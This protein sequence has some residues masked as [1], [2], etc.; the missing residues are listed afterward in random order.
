MLNVLVWLAAIEIVGIAAFPVAY[1]LFPKLH[2]RGYSLAKPL[3]VL[4]VAYVSWILSTLHI[5]PSTLL[6]ILILL[7][8]LGA[9]STWY[10]IRISHDLISLWRRERNSIIASEIIFL[11]AFFCWIA[12]RAYDPAINHTEQPM[13]FAFLNATIRS[14]VGQPADPWLSG[15]YIS[16]YYFGYWMMSIIAKLTN[17]SASVSYNLGLA[18]IPAMA[19]MGLFGLVYSM[20]RAEVMQFPYRL[21]T[22]FLIEPAGMLFLIYNKLIEKTR[23]LRAAFIGGIAAAILV[24]ATANLEGTLEFA[25]ANGMGS[26]EFWKHVSIQGMEYSPDSLSTSW[27]PEEFW[28]WWRASRVISTVQESETIDYTIQEFPFFSFML[29]DLHPHVMSIPFVLLFLGLCWNFLRLSPKHLIHLSTRSI[30]LVLAIG[31]SLGG[32]AF[33]NMWDLPTFS[34]VLFGIIVLKANSIA[35]V[36]T[37][38]A[39]KYGTL[40]WV[41]IIGVA[42][43]LILPYLLIFT[44]QVQGIS[45]V[46][47]PATQ[48][49]HMVIVWGLFLAVIIP[50]I[51]NEFWQTT[52]DKEW[53]R[54]LAFSLLSGFAPFIIWVLLQGNSTGPP[55]S[56]TGKLFDVGPFALLVSISVYSALWISKHDTR[57]TGR[58]FALGLSALGLLLIMIPELL[59]VDDS[60]GSPSERMNTVFKLYYQAWIVLA[61]A[62]GFIVYYWYE[63][64]S[65]LVGIKRLLIGL[66]AIMCIILMAS[67]TYYPAAAA[68]SKGNLFNGTMTLDGLSHLPQE[69]Y[70]AIEYLKDKSEK[71]TVI[72]EAVGKD[73]TAFGRISG[74]TGIPTVLGWPG[75]QV[76]WRGSNKSFED[77][78]KDVARIYQTPDIEEA[79][80][81][82]A[83]YGV[84]YVYIGQR[85]RDAYGIEGLDKFS[86]SMGKVFH[87]DGVAIYQ[88]SP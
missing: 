43:V 14:T 61:A 11:T 54:L 71:D 56:I 45:P 27:R 69:E 55:I 48:P 18:L 4:I 77:R 49:L 34:L 66:W 37:I 41:S 25:R 9:A 85:E 40:L 80:S 17:I 67:A 33:T 30:T 47:T 58:I 20:I 46:V 81:L 39:M 59:F 23:M 35:N 5:L 70:A 74:S 83:K 57:S 53:P 28:W 12:Y 63:L 21:T 22:F 10:S 3:G 7:I 42:T 2:D 75:H 73:Y 64:R 6:T 88:V 15:E 31:L 65:R 68:T 19:A 86:I 29:G 78:S 26:E 36:S 50:F 44:S 62:S 60:F 76:Q 79:K 13:D 52:V 1:Y 32:I 16:Y 82:L 24:I 87:M 72:L 84:Q 38:W 8:V 51:I